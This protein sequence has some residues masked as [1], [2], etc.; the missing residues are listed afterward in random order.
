MVTASVNKKQL[1]KSLLTALLAYETMDS[2]KKVEM[3][4][5]ENEY[6]TQCLYRL[7]FNWS[8]TADSY[9]SAFLKALK[10][11]G[12]FDVGDKI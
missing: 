11:L 4:R 7:G 6:T 8:M 12:Y 2:S 9:I 1:G 5:T 3:I 10:G